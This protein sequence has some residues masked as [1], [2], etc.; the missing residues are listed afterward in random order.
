MAW[1]H[2]YMQKTPLHLSYQPL[3]T[4]CYIKTAAHQISNARGCRTNELHNSARTTLVSRARGRARNGTPQNSVVSLS[5]LFTHIISNGVVDTGDWFSSAQ[6]QASPCA[7][8]TADAVFNRA[9]TWPY[10]MACLQQLF[11]LQPGQCI[12]MCAETHMQQAQGTCLTAQHT[13]QPA[14]PQGCIMQQCIRACSW[15]PCH[16]TT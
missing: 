16:I 10:V 7:K 2:Q 14:Q 13:Q 1:H 3:I 8:R 6:G 5:S 9:C 15:V 12:I 4:F 11:Q